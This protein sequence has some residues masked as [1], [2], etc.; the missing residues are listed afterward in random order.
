LEIA[1]RELKAR[2]EAAAAKLKEDEQR[3]AKK[4]AAQE[5]ELK[6]ERSRSSLLE[7]ERSRLA[8]AL[9]ESQARQTRHDSEVAQ[10]QQECQRLSQ[11]LEG[12]QAEVAGHARRGRELEAVQ[13]QSSR[14]RDDNAD[15]STSLATAIVAGM[16]AEIP[17]EALTFGREMGSGSFGQVLHCRL[18]G[19]PGLFAVK[20]INPM[21]TNPEL[22]A[23]ALTGL[24]TE[25]DLLRKLPRH[26]NVVNIIGGWVSSDPIRYMVSI[27]SPPR[28]PCSR[29]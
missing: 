18:K 7:Q 8:K 22:L 13:G 27:P 11:A 23:L 14:D 12:L 17:E 5:N 29:P 2:Y 25:I 28:P 10:A 19:V 1:E 4:L 20:R 24:R 15:L 3:L 21:Q 9:E 16:W 6:Q 26:A